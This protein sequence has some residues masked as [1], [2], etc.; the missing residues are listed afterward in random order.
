MVTVDGWVAAFLDRIED[1]HEEL[2]R[3]DRLAGDGDFGDNLRRAATGARHAMIAGAGGFAALV[4][5]FRATGGTSGPLFGLWFRAFA[6][7]VSDPVQAGDVAEAARRGLDAIVSAAGAAVGDNTMVDAM[8]PAVLSFDSGGDLDASLRRAARESAAGAEST[9]ELLGRRGR[10]SYVGEHAR[11]VVD[12][13]ALA[14]AWFFSAA[15][16]E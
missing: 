13:G 7:Q 4:T 5:A 16:P 14:V 9:R 3:L 2:T 10:S 12:P 8:A 6:R 15:V 11:G 1:G